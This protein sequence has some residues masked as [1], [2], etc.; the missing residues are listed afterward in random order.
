MTQVLWFALTVAV[1]LV[2]RSLYG[3]Y[4]W[5]VLQPLVVSPVV[6]VLL[7]IGLKQPYADYHTG[8]ASLNYLLGPATVAFAIPMHKYFDLLKRHAVEIVTSVAAGALVAILTSVPL[9]KLLHLSLATTLSLAPRSVTTPFAMAISSSV[10]GVPTLTAVFVIVTGVYG[11]VVGPMIMRWF[12]IRTPVA[13]GA[14]MGVGAHGAGTAKAFE[15]GQVEGTV[16]SLTMVLA[17]VV[18]LILVPLV[19]PLL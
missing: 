19:L 9:A 2:S 6:L 5:V 7:L 15:L 16:S 14:L 1:Y 17:G 18:T 4:K 3:R 10:G 11:G 13:R 12:A 8:T